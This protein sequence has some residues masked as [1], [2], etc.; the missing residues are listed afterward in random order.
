MNSRLHDIRNKLAV[1]TGSIHAFIDTKL[2]PDTHNLTGVL[3]ALE[4]ID[5][6]LPALRAGAAGAEVAGNETIL[7]AIIEGSPFAKVLVDD[8][9]RIALVNAQTESL[10]GYSREELLG[11]SIELLVPL[12]FRRGHPHLRDDFNAAPSA[13]PMGAG[14]DLFGRR[15]DGS[16]FPI[17]IGLNPVRTPAA[18]FTLAAISDITERKRAEEL[19]LVHAGVAQHAEQLE[20]LNRELATASRFKTQFI[21]TMTHELR[22]PLTAIVGATELLN[23]SALDERAR[24]AVQTITEASDTLLS[25]INSVL[26]FSKVQAGKLELR[27]AAFS[28]ESVVEG[29]AEVVAQLAREKGVTLYTYVDQSIPTLEGDADRLRQILLNLLGNAVKFTDRGH[30]VARVVTETTVE[31]RTTL[32]FEVE[33]SGIGISPEVV[34]QLFEPFTQAAASAR[35]ISGTGLGLSIARGLVELMGGAIGVDSV[36]GTGSTFWFTANFG[37]AAEPLEAHRRILAGFAGLV[38]SGDDTWAEIIGRYMSSWSME[39]RRVRSRDGLID[40]MQDAS[41]TWIAIVDLENVG[42]A[43]LGVTFNILRAILPARIIAVGN[44][45]A[46]RKP[47]RQSSL[48]DAIVHAAGTDHFVPAGQTPVAPLPAAPSSG[49]VLVAEDN[50]QLV[51]LLKLQF[52]ELGVRTVFVTD[53]AQAV[54]A[55]RNERYVLVF[56]DCQMPVMDGLAAARAIRAEERAR[57]GHVPIAAMTAN[58]FAEDRDACLAAGMDDYLAKPVKLR[59]LHAMIERWSAHPAASR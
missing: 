54:D 22:T 14:R 9:G 34:A 8:R 17:E 13:R 23:R 59:D 29:T 56:M 43:D 58:A 37:V 48:Y 39:S 53:G 12:R 4:E 28:V 15:R 32:R 55:V 3:Q 1:A 16:E 31:R 46:L 47:M 41:R 57:G 11:Q 5:A 40:A 51:R 52:D 42:V 24:I 27:T 49:T 7:E 44:D 30:V 21:A 25:L 26:D 10:F 35:H 38:V 33:D 36:P 18:T 6:A 2:P 45:S 20:A 50:A 19:R